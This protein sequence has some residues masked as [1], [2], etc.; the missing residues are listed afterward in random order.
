MF[1]ES[2]LDGVRVL[3][4][5]EARAHGVGIAFSDR[6]G[7]VSS[8]PFEGLNLA[9]RVGD[10]RAPV[11]E[12]RR[13][14]AAAAGFELKE[15]AL[16]RQVHGATAIEVGP[17]RAGVVGEAD[18]LYT[19]SEGVVIGILTADCAPVIV[20]GDAGIAVA[21]AGW[22]GVVAGAVDRGVEVVGRARVAW[23]GPAIRSCCYEVGPDV[24]GAFEARG[25]RVQGPDR[26]DP[27]TAAAEILERAGVRTVVSDDCTHHM[28]RYFSYRR[29]GV[30]GRQGAFAW[31]AH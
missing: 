10:E 27:A 1:E 9:L 12:N 2:A 17:G 30:T 4:D 5:P 19:R 23:I 29:D 16:A 24:V 8:P 28:H 31:I 18:V 7:G 3:S 11:E 14:V 21:H 20:V 25:L 22:R 26:V 15:L 13:R 6:R